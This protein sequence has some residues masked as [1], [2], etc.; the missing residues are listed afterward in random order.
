MQRRIPNVIKMEL[1]M[2]IFAMCICFT[3]KS[4]C[5]FR[6]LSEFIWR[7]GFNWNR[8]PARISCWQNNL[9]AVLLAKQLIGA[10]CNVVSGGPD[11]LSVFIWPLVITYCIATSGTIMIRLWE[12]E[13]QPK[14]IYIVNKF[15]IWFQTLKHTKLKIVIWSTVLYP[16]W[17]I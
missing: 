6:A 17:G 16:S 13:G 15:S 12:A 1:L 11:S 3:Y 4:Y 5:W 14:K 8:I 2:M 7:C 9:G 10:K